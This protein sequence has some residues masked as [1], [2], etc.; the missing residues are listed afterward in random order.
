MLLIVFLEA[1][2][3]CMEDFLPFRIATGIR[4]DTFLD[5]SRYLDPDLTDFVSLWDA[6]YGDIFHRKITEYTCFLIDEV[7]VCG[8]I[9]LIIRLP[10]DTRKTPEE[11]LFRHG[12]YI[13]VYCSTSDFWFYS[14]YFVK[15]IISREVSTRTGITDDVAVLVGT[16]GDIMRKNLKKSTFNMRTSLIIF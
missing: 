5:I 1:R 11:P 9:A 4:N 10:I 7:C 13:T 15:N 14:F 3:P 6:F 16:H 2:V 8:I 12:F